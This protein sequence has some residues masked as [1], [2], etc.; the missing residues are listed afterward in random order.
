M[1]E[2]EKD[3]KRDGSQMKNGV[4][5]R[6]K[7][8]SFVVETP[9]DPVTNK[10]RP[11]WYSGYRTRKEAE[12]A[13]T[14]V[15]HNIHTGEYVE[16]SRMTMKMLINQ[17][18]DAMETS[19]MKN[20]T[21]QSYKANMTLHVI[22]NIGGT[23]VQRLT[24]ADLNSLYRRLLSEGRVGQKR[25]HDAHNALTTGEEQAKR[26]LSPKTV[27]NIHITISAALSYA[28]KNNLVHRN[29]ARNANPPGT[30]AGQSSELTTWTAQELKTFL[31][32]ING[33]RFYPAYLLAATTGMRRAEVLG[34][35]WS[36]IDLDTM[37][38]SVQQTLLSVNYQIEIS[39]PKTPG[40][41]R[42]IALDRHTTAILRAHRA[43]QAEE[44][45]SKGAAYKDGGLVFTTES[46]E[47]IHPDLF[48]KVFNQLVEK[49]GLP[50][51]RLHDLRHTYATLA[52]SQGIHPK[53]VAERLGHSGISM[54][55]NTYTHAIPSLQKDAANQIAALVIDYPG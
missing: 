14:S 8:W 43:R 38:L 13:R 24:P 25:K 31:A 20:S 53:V 40:S 26:G 17:Y 44:H 35:R 42:A 32:E 6:G 47:P 21:L 9:R 55:M 16:P 22:P 34:L 46:G 51:I 4:V 33:H 50:R 19:E 41:R 54:T 28:V 30:R 10:R 45:L 37:V 48:S 11:K 36:D 3:T 18:L 12:Q 49:S 23:R 27:R 1:A 15:L 2:T 39:E 52:L 29:V 7:R 5:K